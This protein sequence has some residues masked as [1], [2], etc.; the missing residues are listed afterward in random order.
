MAAHGGLVS[1]VPSL[2]V[3]FLLPCFLTDFR[4][5]VQMKK[6]NGFRIRSISCSNK[7]KVKVKVAAELEDEKIKPWMCS[8]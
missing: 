2:T 5:P 8:R 7:A 1:S 6:I 3:S 4:V